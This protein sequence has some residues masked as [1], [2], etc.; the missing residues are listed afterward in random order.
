MSSFQAAIRSF[1]ACVPTSFPRFDHLRD[2]L[3]YKQS[4]VEKFRGLLFVQ[5]RVMTHILEHVVVSDPFL[6]DT[7]QCGMS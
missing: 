7:Q 1:W 3:L 4:T 2:V 5:Q 6:K